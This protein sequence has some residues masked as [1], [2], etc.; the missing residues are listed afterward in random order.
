MENTNS[1]NDKIEATLMEVERAYTSSPIASVVI[2]AYVLYIAHNTPQMT[3]LKGILQANKVPPLVSRMAE[4]RIGGHWDRYLPLLTMFSQTDLAEYFATCTSGARLCEGGRKSGISSSLPVVELVVRVLDVKRGDSVCDLGCSVGDFIRRAYDV[5]YDE[6]NE[7]DFVGYE[8]MEEP[9]AMAAVRMACDNANVR[10]QNVDVFDKRTWGDKFD[11]VFCEPPLGLR[12]IAETSAVREFIRKTFPDFPELSLSMAADWLF[13]ARAV[14][15]MKKGGRAAVIMLPS[16]MVGVAAESYRRYFIQRNLIEAVVELPS[17]IFEHTG[18]STY[19]VVFREGSESVKMVR[20]GDLYEKGRRTNAIN[21]GHIRVI[22]GALG[23]LAKADGDDFSR[24]VVEVSKQDILENDCD[25]SVKKRFADPVAI[26][27]GVAF[28]KFVVSARRG[29]ALSSSE[30]DKL[31]CEDETDFLYVAPGNI[32]DGVIDS[33][34]MYLKDVPQKFRPYCAKS[35]DIVITRV[36]ATGAG[37]KA[38]VVHVPDGKSLLPNGNLLVISVDQEQT[39][40]YFIKACLDDE[41]AQRYLQNCSVG[42]AVA[43]LNYRDLESLPIPNL[44]IERQREIASA[45]RAN[46]MAVVELRDR[47]AAAR[48]SLGNVLSVTAPECFQTAR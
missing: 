11:K 28:G 18:I 25:L 41:Y 7:S 36:S 26:K 37:F 9:A 14:A 17:R 3:D 15:A 32:N 23:L 4:E 46:A 22:T 21:D 6:G 40:P 42:S 48:S 44:P 29:A 13:A 8:L 35:G 24:Y 10:I 34:L 1:M 20:A 2:G 30:L 19:L 27:D 43:M 33:K 16:A 39:D 47:L 12:K 45:C 31:A 5:A 38:A